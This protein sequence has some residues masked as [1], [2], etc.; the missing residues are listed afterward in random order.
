MS[1]TGP[2]PFQPYLVQFRPNL[3]G[4]DQIR[5]VWGGCLGAPVAQ[6]FGNVCKFRVDWTKF[7]PVS[8][9]TPAPFYDLPFSTFNSRPGLRP[10]DR[11]PA[12][13]TRADPLDAPNEYH[14]GTRCHRRATTMVASMFLNRRSRYSRRVGS[15]SCP[16]PHGCKMRARSTRS[17]QSGPAPCAETMCI[18][19][20]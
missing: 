20:A 7:A 13:N 16:S 14:R 18:A 10:I 12:E 11:P 9:C 6:L 8:T 2:G 17:Q 1:L 15:L 5:A 19:P 3:G 4:L